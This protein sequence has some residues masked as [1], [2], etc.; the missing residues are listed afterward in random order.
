MSQITK[1]QIKLKELKNLKEFCLKEAASERSSLARPKPEVSSYDLKLKYMLDT[2][3]QLKEDLTKFKS[4][5]SSAQ[6]DSERIRL[7][8]KIFFS[9]NNLKKELDELKKLFDEQRLRYEKKKKNCWTDA[10]LENN[11][12]K[13]TLLAKELA[14]VSEDFEKIGKEKETERVEKPLLD[15]TKVAI[16]KRE[17]TQTDKDFLYATSERNN[18]LNKKLDTIRAG[19]GG[20]RVI[21][22]DIGE[23]LQEQ[24]EIIEKLL[25]RSTVLETNID[26]SN[27]KVFE[28]LDNIGGCQKLCPYIFLIS[29]IG[30]TWVYILTHF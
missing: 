17:L 10:E 2:L 8:N 3:F 18:Q 4:Y 19:L 9:V 5:H 20:L 24:K 29:M 26:N 27:K 6:K 14:L 12:K 23:E 21:S 30:V 7:E 11:G 25:D 28:I 15:R 1:L 22:G 13:L 16:G